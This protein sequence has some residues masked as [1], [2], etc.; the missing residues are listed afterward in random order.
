MWN[1]FAF[2]FTKLHPS[3]DTL[4]RTFDF[5][6][7]VSCHLWFK[8]HSLLF[9]P[10][11]LSLLTVYLLGVAFASYSTWLSL[12]EFQDLLGLVSGIRFGLL[13]SERGLVAIYA[14]PGIP[15]LRNSAFWSCRL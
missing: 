2:V 9:I 1:L 13:G 10:F 11:I 15:C 8:L 5:Y 6:L 7:K 14:E 4:Y 3:T 12:N